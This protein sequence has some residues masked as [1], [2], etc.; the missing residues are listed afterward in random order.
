MQ[1]TFPVGSPL[2]IRARIEV[3][4]VTDGDLLRGERLARSLSA[5]LAAIEGLD[6]QFAPSNPA[7]RPGAKG[8][9]V[10]DASLWVFL[11]ASAS[12]TSR[13]LMSAIQAWV[14]REKHRV[15]RVTKGDRTI[16]IPSDVTPAQERMVEA[17][18]R[19]G[20]R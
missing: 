5:E 9:G 20:G 8:P 13:V 7:P 18:L 3:A 15:V 11:A 12:A 19:D 1:L 4:V 16:E 10:A 17:F 6:V 14:Q 2:E